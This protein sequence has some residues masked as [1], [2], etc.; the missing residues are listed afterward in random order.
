MV[1]SSDVTEADSNRTE[2]VQPVQD[3]AAQS[4][5]EETNLLPIKLEFSALQAGVFSSTKT[6]EDAMN[7][8]EE[9]GYAA[10]ILPIEDGK[11]S[12][13]IGIGNK[14]SQLEEYKEEYENQIEEKTLSKTLLFSFKDLKAPRQ[15]DE[16]YITNG[17]VLLQNILILSNMPK[18]NKSMLDRT[19]EEFEKWKA[20]RI[21]QEKNWG[22]DTKKAAFDYEKQLGGAFLALKENKK[23][24]LDWSFQQKAMDS[25]LYYL[26]LLDTLK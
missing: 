14:K 9:K 25:F 15:A 12:V 20:Y 3:K 22:K 19:L 17:N 6:A 7:L 11:F 5:N 2:Q 8:I 10:S 4:S 26:K 21:K 13:L 1:F 23:N 24:D 18:S 16:T